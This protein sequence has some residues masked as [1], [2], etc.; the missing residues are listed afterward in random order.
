MIDVDAVGVNEDWTKPWARDGL[1]G[2]VTAAA[3]DPALHPHEPGGTRVGGRWARKGGVGRLAGPTAATIAPPPEFKSVQE[4]EE[5]MRANGIPDVNLKGL[6]DLD[7]GV[8]VAQ[9]LAQGWQHEASMFP[10]LRGEQGLQALMLSDDPRLTGAPAG[11]ATDGPVPPGNEGFEGEGVWAST[12]SWA[13]IRDQNWDP[14][15]LKD[16]P[17]GGSAVVLN[18]REAEESESSIA[19]M[20]DM[21]MAPDTPEE[22]FAHELGHVQQNADDAQRSWDAYMQSVGEAEEAMAR[23]AGVDNFVSTMFPDGQ[24]SPPMHDVLGAISPY[25][26]ASPGEGYAEHFVRRTYPDSADRMDPE[27]RRWADM[28]AENYNRRMGGKRL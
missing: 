28:I 6:Y 14:D 27:A 24:I 13:P 8:Y 9:Q 12:V 10:E 21:G 4:A 16:L 3:F 7:N 18:V 20:A 25:A 23:E 22:A 15:T 11:T 1:S 2:P 19:Y 26:L 17:W 5:W